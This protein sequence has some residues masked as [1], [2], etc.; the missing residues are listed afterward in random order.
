GNF[1]NLRIDRPA[2]NTKQPSGLSLAALE[3]I[4]QPQLLNS[5]LSAREKI[6]VAFGCAYLE[7]LSTTDSRPK[8]DIVRVEA[9]ILQVIALKI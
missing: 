7:K 5:E 4:S 2:R 9:L 3:E 1:L 8:D 6:V